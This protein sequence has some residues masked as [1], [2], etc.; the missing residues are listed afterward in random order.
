[1]P[2]PSKE[3]PAVL[4]KSRNEFL[5]WIEG[6]RP[7]LFRYCRAATP[8]VW[9][10]ED[11]VQETLL[12][13]FARLPQV[14]AGIRNPRAYLFRMASRIWID[15]M[16]REGRLEPLAEGGDGVEAEAGRAAES[17]VRQAASV[18]LRSLPPRERMAVM[19]KDV[20]GFS[21]DEAGEFLDTTRGAVK[22]ALHRARQ[23]L[24][25]VREG[26]AAAPSRPPPGEALLDAVVDAFNRK[27]LDAL[28][29]LFAED[30]SAEVVG[31]VQEHGR[32]G[33]R[34]GS[35]EHTLQEEG[36]LRAERRRYEGE[37][38]V[39]L[40]YRGGDGA[41][42]VGDVLRVEEREGSI[43]RLRYYFFCP[44]TLKEVAGSLKLPVTTWG[45]R[46]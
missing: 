29:G 11:L 22:A 5:D 23:G 1:M 35:L 27:D 44:E 38:L 3:F 45:Y 14:F 15:R 28:A 13:A 40:W 26:E 20:F 6:V 10:A 2:D 8:S 12:Q 46:F 41:E 32:A 31:I 43:R 7:D 18:L 21:L 39:L 17:E 9:D 33:I 37:P 4:R 34:E 42:A 25:E 30:A 19:L 36:F 16:R 24:Q